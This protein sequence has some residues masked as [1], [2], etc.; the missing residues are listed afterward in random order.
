MSGI[1]YGVGVG[2]GDPELMTLKASRILR[3][4]DMIGIPA[5]SP[6]SCTAYQIAQKAVPQ[7]AGKPVIAVPVPM[8]TKEEALCAAYDEGSRRLEAELDC[9]KKIAFV[10]LGD[11][12][13]YG[14]YM[15]LN[16]R[17]RAHG[18][19]TEII[20]GVPSFCAAAASLQTSLGS[21]DEDIHI[22]PGFYRGDEIMRYS[23]TRILMKSAGKLAD[24]R[25]KLIGL[26]EEGCIKAGAVV[27]CGMEHEAVCS[28]ICDL[29]SN[30]GYFTTIIVKEKHDCFSRK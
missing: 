11:P 24:V 23:G 2:P 28:N 26:Q 13:V 21:G 30:A 19:Q 7:I 17:V 12:T 27:N 1:L 16:E 10:N 4:C 9:D 20:S 3:E 8:T 14:T 15:N 5:K 22:F 18:Y 6:D 25:E 29:D